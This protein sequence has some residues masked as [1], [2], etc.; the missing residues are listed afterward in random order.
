ML[1]VQAAM[2]AGPDL[3]GLRLSLLARHT[4]C[5]YRSSPGRQSGLMTLMIA[6]VLTEAPSA[7]SSMHDQADQTAVRTRYRHPDRNAGQSVPI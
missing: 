1:R 3:S 5:D 4:R 2:K 7:R 6:A